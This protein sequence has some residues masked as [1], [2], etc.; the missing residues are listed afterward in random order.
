MSQAQT[1]NSNRLL[2]VSEVQERL[3]L[4]RSSAYGLIENG[5]IPSV[6]IPGTGSRNLWRVRAEDLE[7]FIAE[8][9]V[10]GGHMPAK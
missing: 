8:H 10:G 5:I 9:L 6:R 7:H 1:K 4:S 3:A 2:R